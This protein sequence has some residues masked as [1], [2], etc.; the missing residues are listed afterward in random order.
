MTFN[1]FGP[2]FS[3]PEGITV[4]DIPELFLF[5]NQFTPP[6][7]EI[8]EPAS[9]ALLGGGL[10]FLARLKRRMTSSIL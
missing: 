2:V 4:D 9:F 10:L 8:P 5:N 1:K 7:G 6:S 3:V